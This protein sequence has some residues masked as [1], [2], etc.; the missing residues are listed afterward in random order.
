[1]NYRP[2][3]SDPT[4]FNETEAIP[5]LHCQLDLTDEEIQ[6][7]QENCF[8]CTEELEKEKELSPER[9]EL[10]KRFM[11]FPTLEK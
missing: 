5:C 2:I 11:K 7:E 9:K 3:L 6:E 10:L 1:M 8:E 4:E